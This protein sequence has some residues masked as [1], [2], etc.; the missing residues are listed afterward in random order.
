PRGPPRV[1]AL[2]PRARSLHGREAGEGGQDR[3]G[4]RGLALLR[5]DPGPEPA[6][7]GEA[8]AGRGGA[9]VRARGRDP[10]DRRGRP[11]PRL[12]QRGP[13]PGGDGRTLPR[14]PVPPP[15]R[16]APDPA[17]SPEPPRGH[18]APLRALLDARAGAGDDAGAVLLGP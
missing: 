6:P 18:P 17:S 5:P 8:P 1:R 11:L 12:I 7:A 9:P 14:G 10:H 16:R 4:G 15:E 2:R 13:A 3:D